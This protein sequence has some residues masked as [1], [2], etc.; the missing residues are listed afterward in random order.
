[1]CLKNNW[2]RFRHILDH[3]L[4]AGGPGFIWAPRSPDLN[5]CDFFLWG[6]LKDT[7]FKDTFQDIP[8]LKQAI[9]RAARNIPQRVCRDTV[10]HFQ[11][12]VAKCMENRGGHVEY[13]L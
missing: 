2:T 1:M 10:T 12:R 11:R 3:A 5:R 7:V 9:V 8:Q 6:Y 4:P 13:L